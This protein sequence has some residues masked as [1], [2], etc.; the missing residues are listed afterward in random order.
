MPKEVQDVKVFLSLM[1]GT[2]AQ[3]K[4]ANKEPKKNLYIKESKKITKFK[5]RGKKYLFTFK[6]AD[7]NKA[8]KIQQTL[9]Q[10]VNK[11]VIG[12]GGKKQQTKK[13]QKK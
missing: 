2:E 6:T 5:L 13:K 7:K 12:N 9:P 10:N 3:G 1:K 4:D 8:Q 11:I